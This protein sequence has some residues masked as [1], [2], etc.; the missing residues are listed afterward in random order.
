VP[1]TVDAIAQLIEK[2]APKAWAEDW[3]NVGLL[4]GGG[5][6]PVEKL[7]LALDGTA[8]VVDEA[9]RLGVQMIV[10]HHPIMFLPLKNLR[11][12]NP[13]AQVP[14]QLLQHNIAYY[15]AHT[16]LDQSELSA[17]WTLAHGLGLKDA[18]ILAPTAQ[19]ALVKLVVFVPASHAEK[20]RRALAAAGVGASTTD[21][22]H[23]EFYAESFF[24]SEGT[25]MFRPLPGAHPSLGKVGE[26]TKVAECRLESIMPERLIDRAVR[27]LRRAHPY[28]E[29]A[30]DLIPLRNSGR[31]R[32]YG[33]IGYF[34]EPITLGQVWSRLG[35]LLAMAAGSGEAAGSSGA[36]GASG[37]AGSRENA[38]WRTWQGWPGEGL[39][40]LRLAGERDRVIRKVAIVNGS[41]G[42]LVA[43]ALSKGA[44]LLITGDVDH[45]AVLEAL[46]ANMAVIDAGHF[47][48]E[49][50]MLLT[51]QRYL[52]QQK[53]LAGTRI[54]V[55]AENC[56]PWAI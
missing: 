5:S 11:F 25:G 22:P 6:A 46:A 53:S 7:L 18:E 16:N 28:E 47:A 19:E 40:G 15:A 10:A 13:A 34:A 49:K 32:G 36:A 12:D 35:E 26:L 24:Q 21:G 9:R 54:F 42:S 50:P 8:A 44:D 56:I 3:D 37:A 45:H 41:G 27:A 31:K 23:S 55:S 39:A 4:V 29:P 14:I 43:K 1:V 17:S 33:A 52:Q 48:T 2:V 30:Y 38:A 51:M 20:V